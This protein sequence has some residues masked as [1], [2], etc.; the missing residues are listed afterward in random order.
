MCGKVRTGERWYVELNLCVN[1]YRKINTNE[2]LAKRYDNIKQRCTNKAHPR[3][4]QY[5][6]RLKMSRN[7]F[8]KWAKTDTFYEMHS[9]WAESGY[10]KNLTPSVDRINNT[11]GYE[12]Q[13]LQWLTMQNHR[14]KS[15]S[16]QRKIKK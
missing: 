10:D 1:C 13:N 5:K 6:N 8:Y 16:E 14:K 12:P 4:Q 3:Y 11:E 15:A 2:F 9:K 7:E